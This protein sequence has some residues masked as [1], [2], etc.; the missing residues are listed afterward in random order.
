MLYVR[1]QGALLSPCSTMCC[2][3]QCAW[4]TIMSLMCRA[5]TEARHSSSPAT[6]TL[7]SVTE[8]GDWSDHPCSDHGYDHIKGCRQLHTA[9]GAKCRFVLLL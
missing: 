7:Q 3:G 4:P 9:S 1:K 2:L 6:M 8:V 5:A